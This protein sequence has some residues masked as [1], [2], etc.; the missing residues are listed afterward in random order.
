MIIDKHKL[1]FVHIPKNAWN[2]YENVFFQDSEEVKNMDKLKNW[3]NILV[4]FG[5]IFQVVI[6]Y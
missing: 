5:N 4:M 2:Q 6:S 3:L 1:V